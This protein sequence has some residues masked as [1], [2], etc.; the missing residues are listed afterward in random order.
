MAYDLKAVFKIQDNATAAIRRITQ[1]MNKL[2]Q[3][4]KQVERS[5]DTFGRAQRQVNSAVTNTSNVINRNTSTVNNN[6][7]AVINNVS[8]INRFS[9]ASR[10]AASSIQSQSNALSGLRN[11]LMGVAGAYIGVQGASKAFDS[12]IGA[13]AK[14]QQQEIVTRTMFQDDGKAAKYMK[15]MDEMA[16]KSAVLNSN[17]MMVGSKAY[18]GLTKDIG[19][20]EKMWNITE[21]LQAFSGVDT[22]Q[23]SFSLKE[24]MQGDYTSIV[25]AVGMDRKEMQKIVKMDGVD[26]KITAFNALLDTMGVTDRTLEEMAN[27]TLGQWSAITEKVGV[28]SRLIGKAPNTKLGDALKEINV[29]FDKINTDVFAKKVGDVLGKGLQNVI[30]FTKKV[31]SMR[32]SIAK[33][34]KV[35]GT[36]VG[37]FASIVIVAK[38]I[39]GVGAA[40][41]FLTSPIGL[42]AGAITGLIY[43][44]KML[45][46]NSEKFRDVINRIKSSVGELISAF[47]TDGVNGL[48]TQLLPPGMANVLIAGL[49]KVSD[50][51]KT[52]KQV[53]QG[54]LFTGILDRDKTAVALAK[55]LANGIKTTFEKVSDFIVTFKQVMSGG[56]LTGILDRDKGAVAKA[57]ALANGIKT[58][59]G[60][61]KDY[62]TEKITQLQ[63]T[64]ERLKEAFSQAFTTATSIISNAL[65]I[66][67]PYLSGLWNLLQILG[68]V[69]VLV[70]NNVIA[71]A[72]SFIAQLFSTLWSVAQPILGAL[73]IGFEVLSKVIKFLWDNVLAPL[74]EFILTGVKNAFD[75]FSGALATVQG[76]FET[77]SGWISTAYGH[78]KDFVA[79]IGKVKMPD[80]IGNIGGGVMK[81]VNKVI[82]DGSHY[83]GIGRIPKNNY[84]ANLHVGERVLTRFEADEYDA[85]MGGEMQ[86]SGVSDFKHAPSNTTYNTTYNTTN[87]N[88]T[89]NKGSNAKPTQAPRSISIAKLADQITVRED[90][91]ID[92]IGRA[93]VQRLIEAEAAGV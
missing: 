69:A 1:E 44:F 15:L 29:A 12:T 85:V 27:S 19:Q 80:W 16:L 72:I 59:F 45:Y 5:S 91:D 48:L 71:P 26:A 38:T 7:S 30:D 18:V 92:K 17:D 9:G 36:F 56:L 73:A 66:I 53:M 57:V 24:A 3:V 67:A 31:W 93:L 52:F 20:L 64:F 87:N 11:T 81:F 90:A 6:T 8:Q 76:W 55:G 34:A 65:S 40:I 75:E 32:E 61:V 28:F 46:D 2:N 60:A 25:E 21:K 68:D 62:I 82:P 79:M 4:M 33:T 77:L 22:Q 13:A 37:A 42:I 88:S 83:N 58:V 43:G 63:P 49:A 10:S 70:F 47:K 84:L 51:V 78:V 89:V 50:F 86:V 39:T 23:A 54:G 74:V 41:A 35:V 14:F